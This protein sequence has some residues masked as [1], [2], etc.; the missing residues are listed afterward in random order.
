MF[1]SIETVENL[2]KNVTWKRKQKRWQD[3]DENDETNVGWQWENVRKMMDGNYKKRSGAPGEND[4][5]T[6]LE[7]AGK[8][9]KWKLVKN[10]HSA[11]LGY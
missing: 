6:F 10:V 3:P 7:N 2:K 9:S 4:K 11:F 5:K 1:W 8:A